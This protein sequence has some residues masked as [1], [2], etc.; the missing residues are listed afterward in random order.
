M[1]VLVGGEFLKEF[2]AELFP[3]PCCGTGVG[4]VHDDAIRSDGKE[5]LSMSF[6]FNVVETHD[7]KGMLI[8]KTD[9]GWKGA[10]NTVGARRGERDSTQMEAVFHVD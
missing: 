2:E 1:A 9:S 3:L 4:F 6:A 7:D 8:E 5:V 10:F